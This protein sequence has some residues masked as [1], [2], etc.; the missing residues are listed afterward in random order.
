MSAFKSKL[1]ALWEPS[2]AK[3]LLV[4]SCLVTWLL[5]GVLFARYGY[6][7]T[8]RLWG[9]TPF[10][11]FFV[12]FRLLPGMVRSLQLGLDPTLKN[13]GDPLGRVFNYPSA[14]MLLRYTGLSQADTLWAGVS[15][16]A[17]FFLGLVLFPGSLRIANVPL[18]LLVSFSPAAMLLYERA[19]VDLLI[20]FLC[21]LAIAADSLSATL[22]AVIVGV[23][24]VLKFYPFFGIMM[25]MSRGRRVF[26]TI[27]IASTLL[28]GSY[29]ALTFHDLSRAW[30]TTNRGTDHSYGVQVAAMHFER[31]V[32]FALIPY[33]LK[34]MDVIRSMLKL[35]SYLSASGILLVSLGLGLHAESHAAA[36]SGRN[37]VAF[38]MGGAVYVGSFLLGNN[39]DYRLV[40][41]LF[42]I[43]QLAE[44]LRD[45]R[46]QLISWLAVIL[47]VISCWYS[48]FLQYLLPGAP[49]LMFALNQVAEWSLFAVLSYLLAATVPDSIRSL[50][51]LRSMLALQTDRESPRSAAT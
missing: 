7:A 45:A 10:R 17:L 46:W 49:D 12:D 29:L 48:F 9:I 19:N 47:V 32:R 51:G 8:W 42:T 5:L 33:G 11:P 34:D 13:P 1:T 6:E 30:D 50:M 27:L 24:S 41:L 31:Q 20:F 18:L 15:M 23:A 40:F 16:L 39:W 3:H 35:A 14:W 21:A 22:A 28:F 43:P 2:P 37:L 38:W 25:F 36:S 26:A 4:V 44:W